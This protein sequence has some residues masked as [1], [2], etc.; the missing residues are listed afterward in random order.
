MT[1]CS[2]IIMHAWRCEMNWPL[3]ITALVI[4]GAA[5]LFVTAVYF[6]YDPSKKHSSSPSGRDHQEKKNPTK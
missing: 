3:T 2:S 5:A 1:L 4:G 6:C